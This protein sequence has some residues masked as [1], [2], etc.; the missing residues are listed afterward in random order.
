MLTR[1][2]QEMFSVAGWDFEIF[3]DDQGQYSFHGATVCDYFEIKNP[4]VAIQRHVDEDWRFKAPIEMGKGSESWMVKEPG[5]YQLAMVSKTPMAKAFQRWVYSELLP[6]LRAEGS[7]V[8][9]TATSEQLEA[10][11]VTVEKY[12]ARL[13]RLL[14][15]EL[16]AFENQRQMA[17]CKFIAD[18]ERR[19][20]ELHDQQAASREWETN[21]L[22]G[23]IVSEF[24][25]Y[26]KDV[27]FL[28]EQ[29]R[30]TLQT[31][32]DWVRQA[33]ALFDRSISHAQ[34]IKN[35][36]QAGQIDCTHV[37]PWKEFNELTVHSNAV[38]RR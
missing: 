17:K 19:K 37:K 31:A 3:Q 33:E 35:R 28:V 12:K 8:M 4:S 15:S 29:D 38:A 34:T 36:L 27:S 32:E 1:V 24:W 2:S 30:I 26:L 10:L 5:L 21:T 6:K 20:Q 13:Q 16:I 23:R 25:I 11:Q 14:K 22:F 9:P 18:I 7:Y